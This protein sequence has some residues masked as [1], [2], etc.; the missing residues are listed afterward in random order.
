MPLR[1]RHLEQ[2]AL[3]FSEPPA[4]RSLGHELGGCAHDPAVSTSH[5][6]AHSRYRTAAAGAPHENTGQPSGAPVPEGDSAG[7]DGS[8]DAAGDEAD[9][10]SDEA[11]DGSKDVAKDEADDEA[12]AGA[13]ADARA[14]A[15]VRSGRAGGG[16]HA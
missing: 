1:D 14:A 2:E 15:S 13:A 7:E 11:A 10:G 5:Q 9:N 4:A 12:D 6:A 3:G 8:S 16:C